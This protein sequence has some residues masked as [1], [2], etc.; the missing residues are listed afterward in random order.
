[1]EEAAANRILTAGP[2]RRS[3][4]RPWKHR[5]KKEKKQ[6]TKKG[7]REIKAGCEIGLLYLRKEGKV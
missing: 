5:M 2:I 7:K 4:F 6:Q 3:T 1:L